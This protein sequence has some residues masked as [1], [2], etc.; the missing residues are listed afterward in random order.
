MPVLF[1]TNTAC[2]IGTVP[3]LE[4]ACT[5]S[6]DRTYFNLRTSSSL[7]T[8]KVHRLTVANSKPRTFRVGPRIV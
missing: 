1:I 6:S 5:A 2:T 7:V 8:W 3:V 4:Q